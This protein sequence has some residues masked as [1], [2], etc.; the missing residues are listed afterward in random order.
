MTLMTASGIG[1]G[2][3]HGQEQLASQGRQGLGQITF[4]QVHA[5]QV[6]V[7]L[8]Q[9]G[10]ADCAPELFGGSTQQG[11]CA[12]HTRMPSRADYLSQPRP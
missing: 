12:P 1:P 5:G 7:D 9:A 8:R 11:V 2:S 10:F 3:G 6:R 4:A